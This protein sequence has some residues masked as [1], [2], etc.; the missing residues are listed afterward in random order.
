VSGDRTLRDEWDRLRTERA[1]LRAQLTGTLDCLTDRAKDPL[2]LKARFRRH[3]WVFAG[4]A[5]GAGALLV[6]LLVPRSS[7]RDESSPAPPRDAAADGPDLLGSLRD[8]A[9]R[10]LA[11]WLTRFLEEHLGSLLA[12][13]ETEETAPPPE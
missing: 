10:A 12:A 8:T 6:N 2:G 11:P 3:P 7:P 13:G 4:L 9:L 5:A 1:A